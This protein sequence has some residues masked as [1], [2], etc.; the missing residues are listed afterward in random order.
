MVDPVRC[1]HGCAREISLTATLALMVFIAGCGGPPPPPQM[2]PP[3][4]VVATPTVR[5]V[6]QYYYYT[7][8]TS[9]VETIEVRARVAGR[10]DQVVMTPS[11]RVESGDLLF[12]I[13]QQPYQIAV[14]SAE[15]GLKSAQA[16]LKAADAEKQKTEKAYKGGAAT[17]IEWIEAQAQFE[18]ADAGVLSAQATLDD[19]QLNLSYTEV[20]APIAG[21]VD[22]NFVDAGNLV[23]Q[24]EATLLT[25]IDANTPIEVYFDASEKIVLEYIERQEDGAVNDP[26]KVN[27]PPLEMERANDPPGSYPFKG[28]VDYVA[29]QVETGTGTIQVRGVFDNT[30]QALIPGLFVRLRAPYDTL[31]N[32]IL[33]PEEAIVRGLAG[34]SV[35][36]VDAQ[37]TVVPKPITLGPS[38]GDLR[39]VLEGLSPEDRVIVVGVQKARPGG[40]VQPGPAKGAM[41]Q[42][43]AAPEA[44]A[45]GTGG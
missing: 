3:S 2:P 36:T 26:G 11:T 30:D 33:V 10:L 39:V 32:A 6:V 22:R 16:Q 45:P 4:V 44:D 15:A 9:A 27:R 21:R 14:K 1:V 13:E 28:E 18:L 38:E 8:T 43:N 42:A 23:G 40:K 34:A 20:T 7:G 19:A 31:E 24:G 17:E 37:N 41:P 25:R 35:M 12:I 29:S 5:D